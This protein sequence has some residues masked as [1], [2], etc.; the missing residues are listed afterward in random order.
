MKKNILAIQMKSE[1][2]DKRANYAKI[3]SMIDSFYLE[4]EDKTPDI[5]VLP[6]V[7]TTGWYCPIFGDMAEDGRETESFL[8][9]IAK[10]YNVNIIG[11]SYIRRVG[12]T[13]KNTCPV[14]L[15]DGSLIAR[16]EKIHLYS[17][18]GEAEF[19][20]SG[21]RPV[22]V[23][24]EGVDIG[25][26]ICYDI[27]FP[28]LFRSYINTDTPPMLL[29]NMS[30]W[31]L[32]RK[33]Q[34]SLMAASRAIENQAYFLALSQTGEIK[35]GVFNSGGSILVEPMGD[36]VIRLDEKEGYIYSELDFHQVQKTR[37]TYP[38]LSN[39]KIHDFGFSPD[40]IGGSLCV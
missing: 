4:N 38:N 15:K 18:D 2:G 27:R 14:I 11:G 29:V 16:Y 24:I 3:S 37:E 32:T 26:S 33:E 22:I 31:P 36:T 25:L 35:D 12:S 1:I 13:C 19:V 39:R 34:Y 8:S 40:Y 9:S 23:N 7:W 20:S 30:A 21:A 10:K 5:I 17:P 28:E 6:E